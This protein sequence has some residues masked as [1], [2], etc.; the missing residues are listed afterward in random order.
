MRAAV[1]MMVAGQWACLPQSATFVRKVPRLNV[2]QTNQKYPAI[3]VSK[4]EP[5]SSTKA[6]CNHAERAF[7]VVVLRC[8]HNGSGS[9]FMTVLGRKWQC[10]SKYFCQHFKSLYC[11]MHHI[12]Q[13]CQLRCFPIPTTE[14]RIGKLSLC[15]HSNTSNCREKR[16]LPNSK[17]AF[18]D[19]FKDLQKRWKRCMVAGGSYALSTRVSVHRTHF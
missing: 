15:L 11:H 1:R 16:A 19:C 12:F 2:L 17:I 7:D 3:S 5:R 14:T 6:Y 13:T 10:R 4:C 18:Q 9:S 8:G